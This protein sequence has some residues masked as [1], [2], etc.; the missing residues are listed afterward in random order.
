[1]GFEVGV[2]SISP[3]EAVTSKV[4]RVG[5]VLGVN[6]AA[7]TTIQAA[8]DAVIAAA[9]NSDAVGHL[10]EVEPGTYAEGLDLD[11]LALYNLSFVA[12]GGPHSVYINPGSGLALDCDAD[13]ANLHHLYFKGFI[14]N[15]P[16]E[17]IGADDGTLFL[18]DEALFEDCEITLQNGA[19]LTVTNAN[20]FKW[21]GGRIHVLDTIAF[22]NVML[23]TIQGPDY[24]DIFE[25]VGAPGETTLVTDTNANMPYYM[26][27]ANGGDDMMEYRVEHAFVQ[28][29]EPTITATAGKI[30]VNVRYSYFGLGMGMT[31]GTNEHMYAWYSTFPGSIT[32]GAGSVFKW[33]NSVCQGTLT[34]SSC[35]DATFYAE[36]TA[37]G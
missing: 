29:K 32:C 23:F 31:F 30:R 35:P 16:I 36:D 14:F 19:S 6:G 12:V 13:N 17:L 5:S 22:Q 9:D 37:D 4:I 33:R 26:K 27:D 15:D 7:Y 2:H 8:I 21:K 3:S 24:A 10:I 18:R 25:L 11:S 20:R 28:R 34:T 1:M